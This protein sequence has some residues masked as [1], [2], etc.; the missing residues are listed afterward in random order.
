MVAAYV[1]ALRGSQ[2]NVRLLLS[3]SAIA[4]FTIDGGIYSV[5]FNLYLL[6][7]DFGPA[8]V[9]QINAVAN[10][11]FA[12]SSIL[13]GWL[14]SRYGERRVM[15]FGMAIVVAGASGVPLTGTVPDT[16]R[17]AWIMASS[18]RAR[19]TAA[20]SSGVRALSK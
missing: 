5:I 13:G 12:F 20:L 4:G 16:W 1:H 2:R 19:S 14:G 9:G 15:L 17:A 7:L 11:V 6:R 3:I 8:F 10:L 18:A